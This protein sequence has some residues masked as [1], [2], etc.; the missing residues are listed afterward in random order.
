MH[1]IAV[2]VEGIVEHANRV[3]L[4]VRQIRIDFSLRRIFCQA[5]RRTTEGL[6]AVGGKRELKQWVQRAR[7]RR[8]GHRA[9]EVQVVRR[10]AILAT[11]DRA[12]VR[13]LEYGTFVSDGVTERAA[14]S[15]LVPAGD[16]HRAIAVAVLDRHSYDRIR[17]EEGERCCRI[18]QQRRSPTARVGLQLS[19][20]R[21]AHGGWKCV[22]IDV[23]AKLQQL[24]RCYAR[25]H[26][27][28]RQTQGV[29]EECF[30]AERLKPKDGTAEIAVPVSSRHYGTLV[31]WPLQSIASANTRGFIVAGHRDCQTKQ[32]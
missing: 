16:I 15:D 32:E 14:R 10:A 26:D 19:H 24:Q 11:S 30:V 27:A 20:Q 3:E 21:L 4:R 29:G 1:R 17:V 18:V 9:A 7:V 5:A 31:G 6:P 23:H 8:G 2:S 25:S 28:G 12:A 13:H 22:E